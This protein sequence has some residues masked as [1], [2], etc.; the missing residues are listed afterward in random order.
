MSSRFAFGALCIIVTVILWSGWY[1]VIRL[2]LTSSQLNVQDLAAL[3]FGVAGILMLPVVW[4]RGL[5]LDRLGWRGLLAI[6]LG[7]GAPFALLVRAGLACQRD[8]AG[9]GAARRR[10]GRGGGARRA[11]HQGQSA[12][13]RP[14]HRRRWRNRRHQP[15]VAGEPRDPRP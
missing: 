8:H 15:S 12:G 6:A 4:K 5:A 11:Y 13:V 3:R 9:H 2:G 14:D 10:R 7:G 1:V